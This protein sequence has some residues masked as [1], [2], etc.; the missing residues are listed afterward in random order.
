MKDYHNYHIPTDEEY[1]YA[2]DQLEKV[3]EKLTCKDICPHYSVKCPYYKIFSKGS[4]LECPIIF[5]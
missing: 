4:A 1:E 5:D 3:E 2:E